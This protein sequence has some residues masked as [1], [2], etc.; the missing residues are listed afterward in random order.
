VTAFPQD[1]Q[2]SSRPYDIGIVGLWYGINYGSVLTYYALYEVL[3]SLGRKSVFLPRPNSL[4]APVAAAFDSPDSIARRFVERRCPVLPQ[5]ALQEEF[6][7]YNDLCDTFVLGSDV[8]WNYLVCGRDSGAFFFLDWVE[9]GH[10]KI[11]YAASFGNGLTGSNAYRA[12]AS[13][14]V[15]AIDRVS[16]REEFGRR[17]A[18]VFFG[19]NDFA[20]VL[21]PVF[22]VPADRYRA[23]AAEAA[24]NTG[25]TD[26]FAYFLRYDDADRKRPILR[27]AEKRFGGN[28]A[29]L[30]INPWDT[31]PCYRAF[32]EASREIPSVEEWLS[33]LLHAKCFVGDSYHGLCFSLIFHIPFVIVFPGGDSRGP[34]E[35][36]FVG[37]AELCGLR[38]RFVFRD[39]DF[40]RVSDI[41]REPI[42]WAEVDRRLAVE[43]EKSYRWLREA[44][45]APAPVLSPE[46][47]AADEKDRRMA[48]T[49]L[50]LR[51]R[52]DGRVAELRE[53][54]E[55]ADAAWQKRFDEMSEGFRRK[56]EALEASVRG[57][58]IIPRVDRARLRRAS[59]AV[60][61][62][63]RFLSRILPFR[64]SRRP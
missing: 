49:L 25:T 35:Q 28:K 4:W 17:S 51:E 27:E 56:I 26:V 2:Q 8:I 47:A 20:R 42:D 11:A 31:E 13:H 60:D 40:D 50:S 44:L 43:R 22:L 63:K 37:L 19:R 45:D 39:E 16:F 6:R 1:V 9:G 38:R 36:R 46:R 41:L 52:A 12:L 29:F 48:E 59:H 55:R 14:Y 32:P 53:R 5:P 62:L 3:R 33:R 7:R 24:G 61:R 18:T 21:D 34:S 54:L 23:I 15:N 57:D 10:K 58:D 30:C 64:R